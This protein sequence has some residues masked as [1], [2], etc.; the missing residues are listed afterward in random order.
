MTTRRAQNKSDSSAAADSVLDILFDPNTI[1]KL[2]EKLGMVIS[3][4]V[5]NHM[6]NKAF[7]DRFSTSLEKSIVAVVETC[8]SN[9]L[10]TLFSDVKV[11]QDY[12][13]ENTQRIAVLEQSVTHL[14]TE[15]KALKSRIEA[16]DSYS[17]REN[18]II[19]GLKPNSYASESATIGPN[20]P[21]TAN[22]MDNSSLDTE[23]TVV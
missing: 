13:N 4:V 6:E 23:R 11:L 5:E 22:S 10:A 14:T 16:L 20:S 19:H 9:K 18:L 12:S 3:S 15:N 1:D 2:G 17:R 7:L 21:S 8:I